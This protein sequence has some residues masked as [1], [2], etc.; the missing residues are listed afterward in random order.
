M[1]QAYWA[2]LGF[3]RARQPF[4][5]DFGGE[6][7]CIHMLSNYLRATVPLRCMKI[8]S[9]WFSSEQPDTFRTS[10]PMGIRDLQS[11]VNWKTKVPIARASC[12]IADSWTGFVH[13]TGA[14]KFSAGL[15]RTEY[16][17]KDSW[18]A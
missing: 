8:D 13:V 4:S 10:R 12:T 15:L 1:K 3:L 9:D 18:R 14:R 7:V 2:I 16:L 6:F 17:V 5:L 11:V